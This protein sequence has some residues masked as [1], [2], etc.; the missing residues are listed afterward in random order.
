MTIPSTSPRP[1]FRFAFER[2]AARGGPDGL[3]LSRAFPLAT[4]LSISNGLSCLKEPPN[5]LQ[6]LRLLRQLHKRLALQVEDVLLVHPLPQ[7]QVAP[8]NNI[9][10]V[11]A[12]DHIVVA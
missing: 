12:H 10:E 8:R 5:P 4:R 11:P 1:R 2:A 3:P 7:R 6:R 9:G